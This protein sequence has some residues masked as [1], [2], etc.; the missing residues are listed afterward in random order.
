M[1]K[2]TFLNIAIPVLLLVAFL[3]GVLIFDRV[4]TAREQAYLATATV[5]IPP[6]TTAPPPTT[7]PTEA[8]AFSVTDETGKVY[9]LGDFAGKPTVLCFWNGGYTDAIE[10]LPIWE[11]ILEKYEDAVH[12]VV[13]HVNDERTGMQAA[14]AYL[15]EEKFSFT[16]Y[17][18]I[19]GDAADA[20]NIGVFPTTYFINAQGQMKARARGNIS[21]ENLRTGLA[22]IGLTE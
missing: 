5:Y 14:K 17:F 1:R 9:T 13:V 10:E 4:Q 8:P 7:V 2:R 3:L 21:P 19:S 15:E 12:L 11:T 22:R 16:A 18:D 20:Y 6:T